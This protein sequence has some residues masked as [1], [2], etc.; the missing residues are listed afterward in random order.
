MKKRRPHWLQISTHVLAW[1]PLAVILTNFLTGQLTVNPIQAATQRTGDTAIVLLILSLACTPVY[2]L[3]HYAPALKIRR[4][5][6]LYAYLYAA[7]HVLIFTGVDY[8]FDF[9]LILRDVVG[10]RF[11]LAGLAAFLLL[12]VLAATSFSWWKTRLRKKWK[13]IHRVVYAVN[14]LVVLHYGWAVKGDFFRL[15]GNILLPLLAGITVLF[16]LAVRLPPVR[17]RISGLLSPRSLRK[18]MSGQPG[19]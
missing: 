2:I 7:I 13:L 15:Q 14:L 18:P 9:D 8:G 16:L 12:T 1:A 19:N 5:L 6:G 11:I 10:K 17:R 3:F 4:P